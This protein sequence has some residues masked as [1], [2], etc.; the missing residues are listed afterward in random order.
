MG[1]LQGESAAAL[2]RLDRRVLLDALGEPVFLCEADSGRVLDANTDGWALLGGREHGRE[3]SL[4]DWSAQD[5]GYTTARATGHLRRA[6]AMGSESFGW[7]CQRA[8]GSRFVAEVRAVPAGPSG[9]AAERGLVIVIVRDTSAEQE[10]RE[11]RRIAEERYFGLVQNLP[12]S[13]IVLCDR[14]LRMV[15]VDGPELETAGYSKAGME[16]KLVFEALAP[17]VAEISARHMRRALDGEH[18]L[19]EVPV[20]DL[21]YSCHY[22]PIRSEAGDIPYVMALAV[23]VTE[24]RRA[25]ERLRSSEERLA[26]IVETAPDP[27]SILREQ[28][29]VITYVNPA[30]ESTFG[31]SSAEIVGRA[32][33]EAGLWHDPDQ[34]LDVLREFRENRRVDSRLI[35]ALT[36]SGE[37]VEGLLS[38][39]AIEVGGIPCILTSFRDIGELR[40]AQVALAASEARQRALGD[41]TF[42]GIAITYDGVVVDTNEQLATLFATTRRALLG[43]ELDTLLVPASPERPR[44]RAEQGLEGAAERQALRSDGSMFPIEARSRDVMLDGRVVRV[45]AVRDMTERARAEAER[46]HLLGELRARNAEMEQFTYTVSHDLK[47]PLVTITGFLGAIEQDLRDGRHERITPD[48]RRIRSAAGKM[49][50]LLEDLLQLSRVGRVGGPLEPV[51]LGELARD[52]AELVAGALDAGHV[53]LQIAADLPVVHGDRGRLL[54]LLQNLFDNAAK[55]SRGA[56]PPHVELGWREDGE[57]WLLFVRDNGIGIAPEYAERVFG[58]FEKLDPKSPG[59]GIGLA[60]ARRIVEFHGGRIWVESDGQG[61]STFFF[62]LPRRPL[63]AGARQADA[64]VT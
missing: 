3:P 40:S 23:N 6:L 34:R 28:D 2:S 37:L 13:A 25:I 19:T 43:C 48:I 16:G 24:E 14:D 8:S 60:L 42:E 44:S 22:L 26:R 30:F 57:C 51:P 53:Q 62:S 29:S 54:Q 31:W 49:S 1:Q 9:T 5:A 33:T 7:V 45:T 46:T 58:L 52:A 4:A 61:G 10:A 36:R 41:A 17:A 27:M 56:Q 35:A 50:A 20:G 47:S 21:W 55:Y 18:V 59:T 32:T 63:T 38:L 39:R 11:A 12:R 15:L 64:R